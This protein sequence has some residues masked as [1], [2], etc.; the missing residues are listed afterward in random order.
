MDFKAHLFVCTNSPEKSDRC[1]SKNAE[2]LRKRLKKRC[3]KEWGKA[4]RIN[5]SGCLGHCE[6]GIACVL[7]PQNQWFLNV[8][9]REK[10]EE[11]LFE[12]VKNA[13]EK[14]K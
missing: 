1:G 6:E 4:V 7:Y 8:S 10:D 3:G 2:D 11:L 14:N 12:A 9:D 13:V 5:S